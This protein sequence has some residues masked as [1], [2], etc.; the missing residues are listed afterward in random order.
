[1][2]YIHFPLRIRV[3]KGVNSPGEY[4]DTFDFKEI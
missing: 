2:N 4:S 1:M 3:V